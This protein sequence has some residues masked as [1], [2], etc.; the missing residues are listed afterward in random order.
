MLMVNQ[1]VGFGCGGL[2]LGG[3]A[4]SGQTFSAS[5]T[6]DGAV[7][8]LFD[9]NFTQTGPNGWGNDTTDTAWVQVQ[10]SAPQAIG[11]YTLTSV[12]D[13]DYTRAP[14]S[15]TLKASNTGI[16][17]G[18]EVT[19]DTQTS[20][21]VWSQAQTRTFDVANTTAY[22]YYRLNMTAKTDSFGRAVEYYLAEIEMMAYS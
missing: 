12:N 14:I 5:A 17:S 11:R 22:T 16:F 13:A 8:N 9:N 15:F 4:T 21:S 7:A 19:I 6:S 3:D 1:L 18:E 10:F 20:I 2:T